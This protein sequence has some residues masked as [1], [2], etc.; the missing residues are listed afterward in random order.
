LL[1][2]AATTGFAAGLVFGA[3]WGAVAASG[4]AAAAVSPPPQPSQP[5]IVVIVDVDWTG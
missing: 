4:V 2:A 1:A 3:G 5:R